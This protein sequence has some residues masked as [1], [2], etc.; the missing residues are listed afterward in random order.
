MALAGMP[1]PVSRMETVQ[2]S[3]TVVAITSTRPLAELYLMA[4]L[5]RFEHDLLHF[6]PVG[7][8]LRKIRRHLQAHADMALIGLALH[9][10]HAFIQHGL[11][12]KRRQV[13]LNPPGFEAGQVQERRR[14]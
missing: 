1:M 10:L 12:I 3:G 8:H 2:Y 4:L 5:N 14:Q 6:I 7:F 11:Q 13:E 9:G